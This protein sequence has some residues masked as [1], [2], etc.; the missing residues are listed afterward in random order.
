[1]QLSEGL[2]IP[3]DP[4]FLP[5]VPFEQMKS[6]ISPPDRGVFRRVAEGLYLYETSGAYYAR[7]RWKGERIFERLGEKHHPCHDLPSAKRLLRDKKNKLEATDVTAARKTLKAIIK[8]YKAVMPFGESTREYKTHYLDQLEKEFPAGK[9]VAEI[10]KSDI[11]RFLSNFDD[12]AAATINHV[13]TVVRDVFRYAIADG[14]IAVSPVEGIKYK[15]PKATIKRLIPSWGEFEAIVASVRSVVFSDTGKESA[16]LIEFMGK[17]GLGQGE[18]AGLT[19][20]DINFQTN[21]IAIIRKKTGQEFTVPLFPTVRPLLERM[22]EE[23]EDPSATARVFKVKDPKKG[24]D[25]ACKRLNFPKYSAR[26]FRRMFITRCLEL[27]I[28]AQTIASWQG[29]KDGGQ[30]ILRVY[31]RV[32]EEHTRRMASLM[33][34]PSPA[35]NI[36]PIG[37]AAA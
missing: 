22:N 33:T 28:D 21:K 35:G 8:E 2:K 14:V 17:A 13:V 10:K 1:M 37:A 16:D 30:L 23:R 3:F 7:F 6:Q 18:C 4:P 36:I 12:R 24:L 32:S 20:G 19:W 25:A 11:L 26:A 5:G 29:H 31:A 9:K 27:G 34:P 15:R